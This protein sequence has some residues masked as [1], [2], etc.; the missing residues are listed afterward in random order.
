MTHDSEDK[1]AYNPEES[2]RQWL[3]S[4]EQCARKRDYEA[5]EAMLH[6]NC[7]YF[8]LVSNERK[9]DWLACWPE[10][11]HFSF[12]LSQTSLVPE[13]NLTIIS[14]VWV[15][16]PLVIGAPDKSG[17]AS[18]ALMRFKGEKVLAVHMHFSR[19]EK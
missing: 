18:I 3:Y 8:G 11:L 7:R 14:S 10:Q 13:G 12:D 5:A 6:K 4:F 2:A 15:A 9:A 1:P 19:M 17:R 16:K